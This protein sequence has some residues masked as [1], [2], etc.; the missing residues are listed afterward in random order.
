[1]RRSLQFGGR[2]RVRRIPHKVDCIQ[3]PRVKVLKYRQNKPLR[4]L[5]CLLPFTRCQCRRTIT[6]RTFDLDV[7]SRTPPVSED[8]VP[9]MLAGYIVSNPVILS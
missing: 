8:V 9:Q 5:A 4:M 3:R 2:T 6:T 7:Y 1:M